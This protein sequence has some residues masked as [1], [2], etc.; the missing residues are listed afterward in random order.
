MPSHRLEEVGTTRH[1]TAALR[2]TRPTAP[3]VHAASIGP[4]PKD[5]E[6]LS[7][8]PYGPRTTT[9]GRICG[10]T[11][12]TGRPRRAL[13]PLFDREGPP[14]RLS[15]PGSSQEDQTRQ[16]TQKTGTLNSKRGLARVD[17]RVRG[18][19][20][21]DNTHPRRTKDRLRL[22]RWRLAQKLTLHQR[23]RS[24]AHREAGVTSSARCGGQS[25]NVGHAKIRV[26]ARSRDREGRWTM[27]RGQ[28]KAF[29]MCG[30]MKKKGVAHSVSSASSIRSCDFDTWSRHVQKWG[31]LACVLR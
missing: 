15:C 6:A 23:A 4:C 12:L 24:A 18:H 19:G 28:T 13:G 1:T 20:E 27:L 25:N 14:T 7:G 26:G 2:P 31:K 17:T 9:S 5:L 11:R 8:G 16:L 21:S 10:P 29:G 22:D 3:A 30:S